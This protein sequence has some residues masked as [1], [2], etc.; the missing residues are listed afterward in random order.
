MLEMPNNPN[1]AITN[2]TDNPSSLVKT[3]HYSTNVLHRPTL[4]PTQRAARDARLALQRSIKQSASVTVI[5]IKQPEPAS[6]PV[7]VETNPAKL[8]QQELIDLDKRIARTRISIRELSRDLER[9]AA[10]FGCVDDVAEERG[11]VIAASDIIRTAAARYG[12]TITD[13]RSSRKNKQTTRARQ[14]AMFLL[15]EM[16][17]HSFS[18]IADCVKRDHTTVLYGVAK[19]KRLMGRDQVLR[20]DI[21]AIRAAL[22]EHQ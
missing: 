22:A 19:I 9:F 3:D 7:P 18:T 8:R 2:P 4:S 6:V 16:T 1:M 14:V 15:S 12:H 11:P 17:E 5:P 20:D 21:S 13:I 10:K